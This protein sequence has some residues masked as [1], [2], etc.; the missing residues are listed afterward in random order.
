VIAEVLGVP[1]SRREE[2]LTWAHGVTPSLDIGLSFRA[3]RD[4]ERNLRAFNAFMAEHL[5]Q[6][7]RDP[8]QD[9]LSR[10]VTL[11]AD[12][13]RLTRLELLSVAGLLLGAGFETTLNLIGN[14]AVLLMR[15]P[16]QQQRLRQDPSLWP[17][18]VEEA[19][20][21]DSPVQSTARTALRSTQVAD[22]TVPAGTTVAVLI[23][24]A[25]RDP[26]RFADPATFD[27]ARPNAREHLAFSA[28]IHFC[29]GAALA[30]LEAEVALRKLFERF[31]DLRLAAEPRR[32]PTRTLHGYQA[33]L[34][35]R[36]RGD[37]RRT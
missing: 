32:R 36:D 17:N 9:I 5:D 11:D 14:A 3:H 29:L 30:R 16:E 7:A 28:G 12:G 1:V 37:R 31:D 34:V 2:L 19:L 18:A 26:R 35:T 25:N 21:F 22:V 13:E 27:V 33:V 20:R 8:G 24:G 6:L 10:L 15:H 4:V 23:G